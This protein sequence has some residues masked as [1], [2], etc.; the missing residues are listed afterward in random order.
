MER[1]TVCALHKREARGRSVLAKKKVKIGTRRKSLHRKRQLGSVETSTVRLP[2]N[3]AIMIY[4]NPPYNTGNDFV[5]TD[6]FAD[7]IARYKDV[8]GQATT[9][10]PKHRADTTK[11][12]E[13][14][15]SAPETCSASSEIYLNAQIGK[16]QDLGRSLG[17]AGGGRWLAFLFCKRYNVCRVALTLTRQGTK[18][19]GR[20]CGSFLMLQERRSRFAKAHAFCLAALCVR[21]V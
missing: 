18:P 14:D 1:L 11:L 19:K 9:S 3:S 7:D 10:N 15:V 8:T 16:G 5:Y 17:I 4:I 20:Y 21:G 2:Y 12:V 6:D 13:H